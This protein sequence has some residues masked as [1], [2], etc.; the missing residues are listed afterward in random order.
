MKQSRFGFS[1]THIFACATAALVFGCA[2]PPPSTTA[3]NRAAALSSAGRSAIVGSDGDWSC[4]NEANVTLKDNISSSGGWDFTGNESFRV[5]VNRNDGKQFK[6]TG[7]TSS[8]AVCIYPM[9]APTTQ[10]PQLLSAPQCYNI[11]GSPIYANFSQSSSAINY[12]VIVDANRTNALNSCL[13]DT[14]PCPAHSEGFV[15]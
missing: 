6:I 13:S 10:S 8:R 14:S 2:P 3:V 11:T 5:C 12:L 9:N 7:M 15:Q 1:I 4:P